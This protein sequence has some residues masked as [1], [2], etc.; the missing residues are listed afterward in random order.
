M[1]GLVQVLFSGCFVLAFAVAGFAVGV[2][3]AIVYDIPPG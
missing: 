1:K 3:R 2:S